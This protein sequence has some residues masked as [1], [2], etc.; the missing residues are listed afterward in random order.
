M[1]TRER[2]SRLGKL[3]DLEQLK[4]RAIILVA[5]FLLCLCNMSCFSNSGPVFMVGL[6]SCG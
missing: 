3:T 4:C 1:L 5:Q 2:L 6:I